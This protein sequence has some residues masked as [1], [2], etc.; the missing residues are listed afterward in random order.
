MKAVSTHISDKF[1]CPCIM[2]VLRSLVFGSPVENKALNGSFWKGDSLI[3]SDCTATVSK[4]NNDWQLVITKVYGQDE[5]VDEFDEYAFIVDE[6]MKA[7]RLKKGASLSWLDGNK[8]E[9]F[10]ESNEN[11]NA[12][13]SSIINVFKE[14]SRD[15]DRDFNS[16]IPVLQERPVELPAE[17]EGVYASPFVEYYV[18]DPNTRLFVPH[19]MKVKAE[20]LNTGNF[21]YSLRVNGEKDVQYHQ[22]IDPH[23]TQHVDRTTLTFIWCFNDKGKISTSSLKFSDLGELIKFSNAYGSAVYEIIN[24]E[25]FIDLKSPDA[26]YLMKPITG[27]VEMEEAFS[28]SEESEY[29]SDSSESNESV[30]EKQSDFNSELA[31]G[32]KDDRA[33]VSRG[34]SIGVFRYGEKDRLQFQTNIKDVGTPSGK[35]FTPKKMMLHQQDSAMILMDPNESSKLYKMD[36][37]RGKVV[38]EWNIHDETSVNN[39]VSDTKTSQMTNTQTLIGLSDFS[40]FRIDPRLRGNKRVDSEMKSYKMKNEFTC[41]TTTESGELAVGSSQGD[42]RLYNKIDKRAKSLLPGFGDEIIG[43]DVTADGKWLVATCKSYLLL[44][45]TATDNANAF[46]KA[47]SEK[48]KPIRLQLK[49]EHLAYINQMIK[50][51]TAKFSTDGNY[52][53]TSTGEY[54]VTFSMKKIR[55]GKLYDYKIKKYSD[56]VV[57]EGFKYGKQ[58]IVVTLP[59]DVTVASKQSLRRKF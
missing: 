57:A 17:T 28:E 40:I 37:E 24:K 8:T 35:T 49:P 45:N 14:K 42:I 6:K 1:S 47:M 19:D 20:I 33:F 43:L 59:N 27:D 52:I 31:I 15:K 32:Y 2:Q 46:V 36:L 11:L 54:I 48:P 29:E 7:V 38:E 16:L 50:F 55:S 23:A 39:I 58:S 26:E 34:S 9:Y 51:T 12:L 44:L 53:V 4:F 30:K 3:F 25:K 22:Q 5:E 21:S 13:V 10:F 18:Y 56:T 41:G